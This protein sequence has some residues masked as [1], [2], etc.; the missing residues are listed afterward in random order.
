MN[1][2][3]ERLRLYSLA[4][5]LGRVG[6]DRVAYVGALQGLNSP[7]ALPMYR[8]LTRR[9][10][11]L[12]PRDLLLT[13]FRLFC[14]ALGI[15]RVLAVSDQNRISSNRYFVSSS[16]VLSSYDV[17]WCENG[18]V[19]TEGGF[20]ELDTGLLQRSAEDIPARKR[21]QYRRRYALVAEL[22]GQIT[23]R[24]A[25]LHREQQAIATPAPTPP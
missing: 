4:F 22:A 2:V 14:M 12:R 11:G 9:M 10:H 8:S 25:E 13:V 23:K 20:F 16:Q 6:G 7:C 15:G 17:A 3:H 18:G 21:A 24:V 5:T 1:L 19:A